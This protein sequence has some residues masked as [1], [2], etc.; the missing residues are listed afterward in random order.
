VR[1]FITLAIRIKVMLKLIILEDSIMLTIQRSFFPDKKSAI[2]HGLDIPVACSKLWLYRSI[3]QHLGL[4]V[5]GIDDHV[6]LMD[7][8]D[9]RNQE[10]ACVGIAEKLIET[11]ATILDKM[12]TNIDRKPILRCDRKPLPK[13]I[14]RNAKPV[15]RFVAPGN[16]MAKAFMAANL[17]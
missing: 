14:K 15:I 3:A 17:I 16:V 13:P 8:I 12:A 9:E 4:N 1:A 2:D 5:D 11:E 7:M 10:L 6:Q